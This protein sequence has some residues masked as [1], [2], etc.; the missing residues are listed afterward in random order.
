MAALRWDAYDLPCALSLADVTATLPRRLHEMAAAVFELL[1]AAGKI[2]IGAFRIPRCAPTTS[3]ALLSGGVDAAGATPLVRVA[4]AHRKRVLIIG[5]GMAGL[6]AARQLMIFG[7]DVLVLEARN[8]PGGRISTNREAV[9]VPVDEGAMISTGQ[10]PNPFALLA[11][12]LSL[13]AHRISNLQVG[14]EMGV[15]G[16]GRGG[17]RGGGEEWL[18]C[19]FRL[20]RG[21]SAAPLPAAPSPAAAALPRARV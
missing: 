5:A 15:G 19:H 2:N 9:G 1:E 16:R 3:A 7:H 4:P 6:A 17:G 14:G 12:Q 13:R 21:A 10:E 20:A 18:S 8:R 11:R